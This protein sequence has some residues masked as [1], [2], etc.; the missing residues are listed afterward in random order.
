MLTK[1]QQ[2]FLVKTDQQIKK[3]R[4]IHNEKSLLSTK[5][6]LII[7]RIIRANVDVR[8]DQASDESD[9][10][11]LHHIRDSINEQILDLNQFF[12]LYCFA[13]QERMDPDLFKKVENIMR[14]IFLKA[15]S[16]ETSNVFDV[17]ESVMRALFSEET[18]NILTMFDAIIGTCEF[19][20]RKGFES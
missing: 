12:T 8:I 20:E 19:L 5:N 14:E 13:R 18:S 17:I 15:F 4:E 10:Q 3:I 11:M 7:L 2:Q 1:E 9:E 16:E 6:V